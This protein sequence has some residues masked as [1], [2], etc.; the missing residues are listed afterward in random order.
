MD[1]AIA[2]PG[3]AGSDSVWLPDDFADEY[4]PL[5]TRLQE[6]GVEALRPIGLSWRH[7]PADASPRLID[8][9]TIYVAQL[10]PL[11]SPAEVA[12]VLSEFKEVDYAEVPSVGEYFADRGDR[13]TGDQWWMENTGQITVNCPGDG[14]GVLSCDGATDSNIP[15]GWA[16]ADSSDALV[17]ILDSGVYTGGGA[18]PVNSDL[19]DAFNSVLSQDFTGLGMND[20]PDTG[21]AA[22]HGTKV[23]GIVAGSGENGTAYEGV[24]GHTS[25]SGWKP[26]VVY[27]VANPEPQEVWAIQALDF[28]CNPQSPAYGKVRVLTVSLGYPDPSTPYS[29]AVSNAYEEDIAIFAASGN[30][31]PGLAFP[32]PAANIDFSQ[33]VA[34]VLCDGTRIDDYLTG[35]YIDVT[36][37]GGNHIE[38]TDPTTNQTHKC[39]SGTSASSPIAAGTASLLRQYCPDLTNDDVY[40]LLECTAEDIGDSGYDIEFGNGLIRADAALQALAEATCTVDVET[41]SASGR[42]AYVN[43]LTMQFKNIPT[44]QQLGKSSWAKVYMVEG[45]VSLVP[46]EGREIACVWTRGRGCETVRGP[47]D[48]YKL[49]WENPPG[50]VPYLDAVRLGT[51]ASVAHTSGTM[52][53]VRGYVYH[54]YNNSSQSIDYGWFPFDPY[55]NPPSPM[56]TVAYLEKDEAKKPAVPAEVRDPRPR[57]VF[58]GAS[59]ILDLGGT[60]TVSIKAYDVSGRLAADLGARRLPGGVHVLDIRGEL[61]EKGVGSGVYFIRLEAGG[62]AFSG[63]TAVVR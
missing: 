29:A 42:P 16:Y 49:D 46:A 61:R 7:L 45:T 4:Q 50:D 17:G 43:S 58:D 40:E 36:A 9:S 20:S 48:L 18:V 63:K 38:T 3:P 24:V 14:G 32:Y 51:W 33:S 26:L 56:F 47:G 41:V 30:A 53:T 5:L 34:H 27:R 31:P 44:M 55:N 19:A 59:A 23:C 11:A 57:A 10:D 8:F 21:G 25:P 28:V 22:Y 54:V 6:A 60:S 12:E 35:N 15:E 62:E 1:G 39:F 2:D 52:Y 13:Y 37:P